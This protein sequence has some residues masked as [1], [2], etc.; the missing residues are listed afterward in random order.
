MS[1]FGWVLN[2][3]NHLWGRQIQNHGIWSRSGVAFLQSLANVKQYS[4][5]RGWLFPKIFKNILPVYFW[6]WCHLTN[7]F[8]MSWNHQLVTSNQYVLDIVFT[9]L[10]LKVFDLTPKPGA[11]RMALRMKLSRGG[12]HF[13]VASLTV[14]ISEFKPKASMSCDAG[15]I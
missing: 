4:R 14:N 7:M 15:S 5:R 13:G 2:I 9:V 6:K 8:Q 3:T 11:T 12:P 1:L 10:Q